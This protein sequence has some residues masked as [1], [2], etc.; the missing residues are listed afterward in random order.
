[1]PKVVSIFLTTN[2]YKLANDE[3]LDILKLYRDDLR[4]YDNEH[5][6]ICGPLFDA[7]PA[8]LAKENR[9]F[10]IKSISN[11]KRFYQ[12]ERSLSDLCDFKIVNRVNGLSSLESPL[13][14]QTEEERFKI[15]FC[16]TGLL[17][18][19]LIQLSK[20]DVGK[21]YFNFLLGKASINLGT[22]Y[23]SISVQQLVAKELNV[24][25]H[26]FFLVNK[27]KN[28]IDKYE[29]DL[30]VENDFKVHVIEIKSAP[31][32]KAKELIFIPHMSMILSIH[33]ISDF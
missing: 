13:M 28:K 14:L 11:T 4:K 30:V 3:K 32:G 29:L 33:M 21:A 6:T 8:Q 15:Y 2:S 20:E 25:Y 31:M 1:M 5:Q 18:S 24:Y 17:I 23:E 22:I 7:I 9:R 16:D 12:I 10:V 26:K 19:K 27:E